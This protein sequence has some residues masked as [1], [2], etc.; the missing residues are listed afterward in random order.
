[1]VLRVMM[2]ALVLFVLTSL[3]GIE[4]K[5]LYLVAKTSKKSITNEYE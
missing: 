3:W 4:G 1:M 5:E 2:V